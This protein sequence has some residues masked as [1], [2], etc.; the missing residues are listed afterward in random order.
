MIFHYRKPDSQDGSAV[1]DLIKRCPP[2]DTN[3]LYCNLL[4]CTDFADTSIVAES[5]VGEIRGFISGYIT[6]KSPD[7]LFIWQV[8]L[9]Q[10]C[11]GKGVA[12]TMLT[13]LFDRYPKLRCL[14]TTISP[15]NKPSQR[16]FL[17]FFKQQGMAVEIREHF[18]SDV[19]LGG[20]HEDEVLYLGTKPDHS[21][22]GDVKSDTGLHNYKTEDLSK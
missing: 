6:P 11:R 1:H 20:D 17:S 19:H 4:Q 18:E 21:S 7:T 22:M 3:S 13:R 2:L 14:K 12:L 16:L 15:S 5:S 8:A 9:D 10:R